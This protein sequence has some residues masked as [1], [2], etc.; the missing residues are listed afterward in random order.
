[1][2]EAYL[3]SILHKEQRELNTETKQAVK[4]KQFEFQT[5]NMFEGVV[6]VYINSIELLHPLP[7]HLEHEDRKR[8]GNLDVFEQ[9]VIAQEEAETKR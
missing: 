1:M 4:A 5:R 8:Q 2:K 7:Q 3:E 9:T 6:K